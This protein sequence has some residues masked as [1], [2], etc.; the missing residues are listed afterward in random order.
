MFEAI[1]EDH[2][3]NLQHTNP[4][5]Y[6][7]FILSRNSVTAFL[8][9]VKLRTWRF[10][11]KSHFD[12]ALPIALVVSIGLWSVSRMHDSMETLNS[13]K[14]KEV[15][16]YTFYKDAGTQLS[17]AFAIIASM[18]GWHKT[19]HQNKL[20]RA[21]KFVEDMTKKEIAESFDVLRR[22]SVEEF[23]DSH[24]TRFDANL[25]NHCHSIPSELKKTPDGVEELEQAQ[26]RILSRLMK[27]NNEEKAVCYALNFLEHMGQDVKW[28]VADTDYLKD[29]FYSSIISTYEFYRKFIEYYQYDQSCRV[30][31][32]NFVYLAQ[33][34]EKEGSIPQ[35]P[36]I[37]YRPLVITRNDIENARQHKAVKTSVAPNAI[38]TIEY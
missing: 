5:G 11:R 37:C 4:Y 18:I 14:Q 28:G 6:R 23:Y 38:I 10:L 16:T 24:K 12:I 15:T 17:I 19:F 22:I 3:Y 35:L 20:N 26:S 32:S 8:E 25:F 7:H 2:S 33:T 34:W 1:P 29:H 27:N 31:F 21:S 30:R 9:E 36:E 13:G